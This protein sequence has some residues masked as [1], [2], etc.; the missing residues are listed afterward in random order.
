[1][2]CISQPNCKSDMPS[3]YQGCDPGAGHPPKRLEITTRRELGVPQGDEVED[4]PKHR[5]DLGGRLGLEGTF[6][7]TLSSA[8]RLRTAHPL[9]DQLWPGTG[10]AAIPVAKAVALVDSTWVGPEACRMSELEMWC[11]V[12]GPRASRPS[13]H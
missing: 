10:R 3:A 8:P 13:P 4:T 2:E 7:G 1:M 6:P 11:T 9:C 5:R 12:W